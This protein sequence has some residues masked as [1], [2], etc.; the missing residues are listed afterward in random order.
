MGALCL[1]MSMGEIEQSDSFDITYEEVRFTLSSTIDS[2]IMISHEYSDEVLCSGR[3]LFSN[4]TG[5]DTRL[6]TIMSKSPKMVTDKGIHIGS[7]FSELSEHYDDLT[8]FKRAFD[9]HQ[10]GQV[11]T[12]K[13]STHT[14]IEFEEVET[15]D[16]L[17]TV[18]TSI[19][20]H[21]F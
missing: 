11:I 13:N 5:P 19:I 6:K 4:F 1:G 7:T 18:V 20:L 15:A 8:M 21:R 16:S 9:L 14:I 17:D 10:K 3:I 2:A 12:I